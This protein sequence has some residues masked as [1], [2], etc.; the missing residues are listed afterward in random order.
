M[1]LLIIKC[2][3]YFMLVIILICSST[4]YKDEKQR[5]SLVFMGIICFSRLVYLMLTIK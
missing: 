4:D 5:Y 2:F 1:I 3:I